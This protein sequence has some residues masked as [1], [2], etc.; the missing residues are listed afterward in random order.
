M[1]NIHKFKFKNNLYGSHRIVFVIKHNIY[2]Q[3][4][5][6]HVYSINLIAFTYMLHVS[7]YT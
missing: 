3:S 6:T 5:T 7:A 1:W 2:V 4:N